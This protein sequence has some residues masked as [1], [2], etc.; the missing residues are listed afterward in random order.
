ME[1]MV[2][3]GLVID[4]R[5][6]MRPVYRSPELALIATTEGVTRAPSLFSS[7]WDSPTSITAMQEFVVPR[8]MP[9]TFGIS[10]CLLSERGV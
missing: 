1:K 2:F 5:L 3:S 9:S 6:A 10:V 7:T 8:S 4:W